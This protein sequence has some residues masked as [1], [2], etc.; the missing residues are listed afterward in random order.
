MNNQ[1][2]LHPSF[3]LPRQSSALWGKSTPSQADPK[4]P[5]TQQVFKSYTFGSK[6][7]IFFS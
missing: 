5:E 6:L 3:W 2:V 7:S 4:Q 1:A